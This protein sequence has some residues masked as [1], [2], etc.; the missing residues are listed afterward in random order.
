M[1]LAD[2]FTPS[3][4]PVRMDLAA[5]ARW[6]WLALLVM[7]IIRFSSA[8]FWSGGLMTKV[9]LVFP[10]TN[11]PLYLFQSLIW[12]T[13]VTAVAWDAYHHGLTPLWRSLR[14][15]A[16]LAAVAVV[17]CA[18]GLNP[19]TS[20]RSLIL[21]AISVLCGALVGRHVRVDDAIRVSLW[22][23][24]GVLLI[25]L[26]MSASGLQED[27]AIQAVTGWRGLFTHKNLF[28]WAA[29][30]MWVLGLAFWS[31]AHWRLPTAVCVLALICLVCAKSAT[32]LVTSLAVV[33]HALLFRA[34]WGKVSVGVG[35]LWLALYLVALAAFAQFVMPFA[36]EMLGKDPTFTGRTEIW[37]V[38][39]DHALDHPW[40]GQG[41]AMFSS[42]SEVTEALLNR[43]GADLGEVYLAHNMYIAALGDI[44]CLGVLAFLGSLVAIV[45]VMP[46]SMDPACAR[47]VAGVGVLFMISGMAENREVMYYG[48]HWF[49]LLAFRTMGLERSPQAS[50]QRATGP[51]RQ[52]GTA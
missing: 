33:P 29:S 50:G 51:Q 21:W 13:V 1:N 11:V 26:L 4:Q 32:S 22:T 15:I 35:V 41:P 37:G 42:R 24:F 6:F 25:S 7:S 19:V 20:L 9:G 14:P 10:D 40:F 3:W 17:C 18:L 52:E 46:S 2:R 38:Y 34:L 23:S 49:L 28:G 45:F 5:M 30:L 48:L 27:A 12:V 44:G 31:R 36:L 43:L 39:I 8:W 16:L 47:L